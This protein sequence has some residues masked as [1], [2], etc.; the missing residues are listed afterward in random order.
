MLAAPV[1]MHA[2]TMMSG[3]FTIQGMLTDTGTSLLIS[4]AVTGTGTQTGSFATLLN[5]GQGVFGTSPSISYTSYMSGDEMLFVGPLTA[6]LESFTETSSGVFAGTVLL[7]SAGF[8]DT[9]ANFV[10]TTTEDKG[11]SSEYTAVTTIPSSVPEPS[12]LALFGTGIL[13]LAS[14]VR[15]KLLR[16]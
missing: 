8:D 15:S 9:T 2:D 10:L 7:S 5:D 13:G 11:G 3:Q 12:T 16:G 6:D 4:S 1:A 14:V